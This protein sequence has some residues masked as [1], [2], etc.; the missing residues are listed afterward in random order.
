MKNWTKNVLTWYRENK[1]QL[2]WRKDRD[3]YHVWISE[4]MLQ[5]TR[6]EAVIGYYDR[7]MQEIPTIFALAEIEDEKLLKL[8]EGLGYY[9]RARNL[10]KTAQ[11]IVEKY[12]GNFPTTYLDLLTLPGIG[13]YTASAISSIC[14]QEKKATVDG[15]VLRVYMRYYNKSDNISEEK[16]RKSVK[17]ELEKILPK[18]S[19]DFN[20]GMM[21]LG[22]V[23][24]IPN[25]IPLCKKCPI[26][27]ECLARKNNSYL[28]L[29][30]KNK[31]KEQKKLYYTVLLFNYREKIAI[32]KRI[33]Q[34]LLNNLWSFPNL[35]GNYSLSDIKNY[36]ENKDIKYKN[37]EE[38]PSYTHTFTHQK[39][40]M[41]SYKIELENKW[42]EENI[43]FKDIETIK[44]EYAIPTAFQP[45][46]KYLITKI[47]R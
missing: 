22:E 40:E 2:P 15:N 5:Q 1:R 32:S 39:W 14:F 20:E 37:I 6:I 4:I 34:S 36:L 24:C 31:K 42:E 44:E 35:E 12:K 23:I 16:V 13:E 46:L 11:I 43:I 3:P 41:K 45:F 8:W 26:K 33:N 38:A 10:K 21:E 9:N 18:N 19:G 28:N 30:V 25:G 29:P 17:E 27:Q 47:H 7:F